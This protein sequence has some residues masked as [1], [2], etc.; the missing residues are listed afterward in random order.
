MFNHIA[1]HNLRG[2]AKRE[3][4][5]HA[6]NFENEIGIRVRLDERVYTALLFAE[7]GAADARTVRARAE[8]FFDDELFELF[9]LLDTA[10]GKNALP[11]EI[12]FTVDLPNDNAALRQ[13]FEEG[14]PPAVLVFGSEETHALCGVQDS[15]QLL[16]VSTPEEAKRLLAER[17]ISLVLIDPFYGIREGEDFLNAE[18]IDSQA[19]RLFRY[20]KDYHRELPIYLVERESRRLGQE[21]RLSFLRL[22]VRDVLAME[23]T[24]ADTLAEVCHQLHQ[25]NSMTLLAKANKMVTFETAQRLVNDGKTAEIRLFD[26]AMSVAMDPED[27]GA[28]LSN[29][30]RPDLSFENVIGAEEAKKELRYFVEYLKNPKKYLS[31]GVRAPRGV[32]MYGPPG[33]GKTLLAK[34]MAGESDVTF[35]TAEGNQFL[36]KYVGEGSELVHDIFRTARKY[37]PAILFIDEIDAIGKE[38]R[39][40]EHG[41]G[42]E[43]TLTAFLT[44]MDGFRC[45]PAKPVFVLAATNYEIEAGGPRSLDP[46]LVRRFDRRVYIDLPRKEDRIRYLKMQLGRHKIAAVSADMLENLAVRSTGMSLAELES[47]I[48]LALR[49]AIRDGS[50]RVS[51]EVLEEAFETFNSGERKQWD[52]SE[53]ERTARHEAGHAFLCWESGETPSYLTVVARAGHGG[54]MQHADREGKGTYT[55]DELLARIRTALGGRAAETVYYGAREG[56][57]TGASGD[58]QTATRVAENLLCRYGMDEA[59]GLAV[60]D[61]Q[62]IR[63]GELGEEVRTA[64]NTILREELNK[65]IALLEAHRPQIDALVAALLERNHLSG[66]EI[67]AILRGCCQ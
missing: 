64:V 16:P 27:S 29:V 37:A 53:L 26:F 3:V 5:R 50:C 15:C 67:E 38:R 49:T 1:A 45:D 39:G 12:R 54:Y 57:T 62:T 23:E 47:V 19:R 14:E 56:L 11:E 44:E 31:T 46:A 13:L 28:V 63:T 58:L 6:Q 8:A 60:I 7:G 18:D 2:I 66:A 36:K 33:T 59:F 22:G 48:E 4:L 25:Q 34:A 17:D 24:F 40:G 43:E 55:K 21:E 30:S 42:A 9:R 20:L 51:D 35:L 65:A 52:L 32:L 41:E 10:G 61:L